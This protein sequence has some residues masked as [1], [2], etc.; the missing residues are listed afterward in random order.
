MMARKILFCFSLFLAVA[1]FGQ[2]VTY[3]TGGFDEHWSNPEQ[4]THHDGPVTIC[5][6]STT[7]PCPRSAGTGMGI[8]HINGVIYSVYGNKQLGPA[9]DQGDIDHFNT[10]PTY[11]GDHVDA[12]YRY[13]SDGSYDRVFDLLAFPQNQ[14]LHTLADDTVRQEDAPD[15][16]PSVYTTNPYG[17]LEA[18]NSTG[19]DWQTESVASFVG[20]PLSTDAS[21]SQRVY[22]FFGIESYPGDQGVGAHMIGFASISV[23]LGTTSFSFPTSGL[24]NAMWKDSSSPNDGDYKQANDQPLRTLYL[25]QVTPVL[26]FRGESCSPNTACAVPVTYNGSPAVLGGARRFGGMSGWYRDGY[27]YL[28]IGLDLSTFSDSCNDGPTTYT[29][30]LAL[31]RVKAD[32]SGT[33]GFRGLWLDSSNRPSVEFYRVAGPLAGQFVALPYPDQIVSFLDDNRSS[34]C[35]GGY[36][37]Q[38]FVGAGT[39]PPEV[40]ADF[41]IPYPADIGSGSQVPQPSAN[42]SFDDS[43]TRYVVISQG[44]NIPST[45]N[46]VSNLLAITDANCGTGDPRFAFA[47][48][49]SISY[50]LPTGYTVDMY[51]LG[52]W[53]NMI[54]VDTTTLVGYRH[55]VDSATNIEEHYSFTVVPTFTDCHVTLSAA[56]DTPS[57]TGG[58][59]SFMITASTSDCGWTVTSKASFITITSAASGTGNATVTYSVSGN[60][61]SAGRTGHITVSD[62]DFFISQ[63]GT[64]AAPTGLTATPT[65]TAISLAWSMVS[66]A[67]SYELQRSTNGGPFATVATPTSASYADSGNQST[68]YIY[69]VRALDASSATSL[70]SGYAF[71]STFGFTDDPI[72]ASTT[73]AKAVHITELRTAVD[74]LRHAVGLPAGTYT[75]STLQSGLTIKAAHVQ[76]LR[77]ALDA[78][79]MV[80][81]IPVPTFTD[82]TLTPGTT[83]I[84][85]AHIQELRNAVK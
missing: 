13:D 29:R 8:F 22:A 49:G 52:I 14:Y 79:L 25:Q 20:P 41:N 2:Q 21:G 7:S 24:N 56:G 55:V 77:D 85:A 68:V 9:N 72:V 12:F 34:A 17:P 71:A 26:A 45:G 81:G 36:N 80:L 61:A 78:A 51:S 47:H 53:P 50:P 65:G 59:N 23:P 42:F 40:A 73:M 10:T 38:Y 82:P 66:G 46:T 30:G 11:V 76:D 69:R 84:K 62:Q 70:Y 32:P 35:V 16:L 39:N 74:A 33:S 5:L 28:L 3:W 31:V 37:R 4:T 64:L 6:S 19:T 18:T 63:P 60:T 75:D 58:N 15:Q 83:T 67:S 57:A 27:F 54:P 48:G 44:V 43:C 1:A